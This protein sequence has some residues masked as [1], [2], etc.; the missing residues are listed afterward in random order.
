MQ[1]LLQEV[2]VLLVVD[3]GMGII[4]VQDSQTLHLAQ[5]ISPASLLMTISE[6]WLEVCQAQMKAQLPL[7]RDVAQFNPQDRDYRRHP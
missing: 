5:M 2:N 6:C 7:H 1:G 3:R 4:Q